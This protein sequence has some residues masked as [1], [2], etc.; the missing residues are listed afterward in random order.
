MEEL[1]RSILSWYDMAP[2][3]KVLMASSCP[4]AVLSLVKDRCGSVSFSEDEMPGGGF[5]LIIDLEHIESS[6]DPKACLDRLISLLSPSGRLIFIVNN[7]YGLKYFCG[8]P[9]PHS[10]IPF[11][12]VNGYLSG[13]AED[14]KCMSRREVE[15]LIGDIPHKYFY[16]MPDARMPQMIYTDGFT[17]AAPLRERLLDYD[18]EDRSMI[19]LE[20]RILP[21]SVEGGA[22]PFLANSFLIE[23]RP[24]GKLNDT[25]FAVMT[26]DRGS[27]R[28]LVTSVREDGTVIKRPL[29]KDGRVHMEYIASL[30]GDLVSKGIPIVKTDLEEDVYGPFLKMPRI[31][32]EPLSSVMRREAAA[33]SDTLIRRFDRIRD[34]VKAA[35]SSSRTDSSTGELI[36]SEAYLDLAPFNAFCDGEDILFY[37]Q[38]FMKKDASIQYVMYRMLKYFFEFAYEIKDDAF[39]ASLY[40]RYGIT[41]ELRQK[42]EV[43]EKDF[44]K[45]VRDRERYEELYKMATPDKE[46][47]LRR[48]KQIAEDGRKPYRIGYVPGVFD[49][50]HRGHINL[51]RRCK[52]RCRY[53][54]V[55]V[56]TDDL[57][58]YYKNKRPVMSYEE[59]AEVLRAVC[60]VDEVI[61]VDMSNTDKLD[62]WEQLHY[63]CHFSGDDHVGHWNDVLVKLRE[64]GSN[65]EFFHYTDGISSTSIKEKMKEEGQKG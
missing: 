4:E 11:D 45:S 2:S 56:L 12:G 38:E 24:D 62:A 61:P 26:E 34:L 59:R 7:R 42:Y 53:L 15:A 17:D 14:G 32:K 13:Q 21:D 58:E 27:S 23:V 3:D 51:L 64:R 28:G 46:M 1:K 6:S 25:V 55:G 30:N 43:I 29:Y 36:L 5:D 33:S 60:Y 9:D 50:L 35:S 37:D 20:H 47:I 18:Y 52:E 39:K 10:K 8:T 41:D 49:L 48:M 22:L 19:G 40:E 44:I 31:T 63:D 54:I 16:P 65:M 57:V